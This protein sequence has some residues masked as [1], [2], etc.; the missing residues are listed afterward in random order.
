MRSI[1]GHCPMGSQFRERLVADRA[2]PLVVAHRGDSFH[3]PENT[4]EAAELGKETG[5]EAWELDV[6]LTADGVAV[7]LHDA[8]LV[9]TTDVAQKYPADPRGLSGYL[10]SDFNWAEVSS[11]DAGSWF[12]APT[13]GS[14][15][16]AAFGTL[17]RLTP[18]QRALY[19]SGKVRVPTLR[20]A[21]TLT[22]EADWLVNV[23]LKAFPESPPRL[24]ET[25]LDEIAATDTVDRVLL[26][27]FDHGELARLP[28][29]VSARPSGFAAIPSGVL[30]WTPL[31]R[32]LDYLTRTVGADCYHVSDEA[33]GS[34]SIRYRRERSSRALRGRDVE[35]LRERGIPVLV[36]T[37]N[38]SRPGGLAEHLA[39]LGVSGVFSDDPAGL[40][41]LFA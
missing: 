39:E 24:L 21:L 7:V 25:V 34:E 18:A 32:P 8:S 36:F 9:R 6:R 22:R 17:D 38:D 30:V 15:T 16:A 33:L 35:E 4:L 11:L 19:A 14:R 29:L 23:E 3:A 10:V 31:H 28:G 2:S 12:I 13:G 27:S 5:A 41:P 37:V 20:D 1:C 26:S 40:C